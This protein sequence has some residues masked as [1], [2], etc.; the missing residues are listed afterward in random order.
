VSN[1]PNR[2]HLMGV[3]DAPRIECADGKRRQAW[4]IE[5]T[6]GA[7]FYLIRPGTPVT[8]CPH[9][10]ARLVSFR[11]VHIQAENRTI[12]C[13]YDLGAGRELWDFY[14]PEHF[15]PRGPQ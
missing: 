7:R 13:D 10:E 15:C 3:S 5:G 14:V 4:T 6:S 1:T 12:L 9:C 8:T 2:P 11:M